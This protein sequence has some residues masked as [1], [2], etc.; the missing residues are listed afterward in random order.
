MDLA[1]FDLTLEKV[2]IPNLFVMIKTL[3][4]APN[5]KRGRLFKTKRCVMFLIT[6]IVFLTFLLALANPIFAQHEK[7]DSL[8]AVLQT[9]KA[10]TIKVKLQCEISNNFLAIK[11]LEASE[12]ANQGLILSE[13]IGY[14]IGQSICLDVLGRAYYQ[15]GKFDSAL[16]YFE[17][18]HKIV[19]ELNDSIGIAGVYDNMGMV[20]VHFR[21][22]EKAIELRIKANEIYAAHNKINMLASGYNWIGTIYK[23]QGEYSKAIEY[24]LMSVKLYE[25]TNEKINISYPLLNISSIYRFLKQYDKAKEYALAAREKFVIA[26][27]LEGEAWSLYRLAIIYS[28]E[29]N[30]NASIKNAEDAK[31]LFNKI[32][33]LY[34][35]VCASML[36]G[37]ANLNQ[38]NI[39]IALNYFE[40]ALPI[41][42][43]M[44]DENVVA[45]LYENIGSAYKDKGDFIKALE[46]FYKSDKILNKINDKKSSREISRNF[47][48]LF[49][50]LNQPDS[51]VA[52]FNRYQQLSDTIFS[53]QNTKSIAE[54]QA[55]YETEKKDKEILILNMEAQKKK[56]TIWAI[57]FG[58]IALFVFSGSGFVVSRNK[59][60]RE[61][62]VLLRTISE[63]D[64]KALRSQMNP[65]FIF[66]CI[67]TINELLNEL[68]IQES[69]TCLD[70]FSYLTRSVLENSKKREIPLLDELETLRLYIDLENMR[71][72]SPFQYIFS[73]EPRI[74]METTLIPPLILQPFVENS[75]K[76]GFRDPKTSGLLKIGIRT[77]NETL[78]CS[79]EDN[80]VGR[81]SIFNIKTSSGFKKESLGIKLTEERLDLISKTKKV[82]SHFLINDLVDGNNNPTGTLVE[83]YLPYELS[84]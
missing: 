30:Y 45:V 83:M 31:T 25:E 54:M 47:I 70:K 63:T 55:K 78:I 21:N 15:M 35:I 42:I 77:Q 27:Y 75:I 37:S 8:L 1:F 28:D 64:M 81:A 43:Q 14:K 67:H 4:P 49:S 6:H 62:A 24:S 52:Y 9:T 84:V 53:E 72:S 3:N 2:K 80:G 18:R 56:N 66:N 46:Y 16:N 82:K 48:E 74:D 41:A 65:H 60:K 7:I 61:Q 59:K 51:V 5:R 20:Y 26:N 68:K 69:K 73:I 29:H 22:Y 44:G 12:Y 39:N 36:E 58:F 71:F 57:S 32:G 17:R 19:I 10:D 34:G 38:G 50:R 33:N 11:P 40:R 23:E 76:H 13:E 79:I